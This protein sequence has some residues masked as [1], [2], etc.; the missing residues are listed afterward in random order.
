MALPYYRRRL[1]IIK[2]SIFTTH[3]IMKNITQHPISQSHH[4]NLP[5]HSTLQPTQPRLIHNSKFPRFTTVQQKWFNT[6]LINIPCFPTNT[7]L[8][9]LN[10]VHAP[11]CLWCSTIT[12]NYITQIK[13]SPRTTKMKPPLTFRTLNRITTNPLTTGTTSI[14]FRNTTFLPI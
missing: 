11:P 4:T 3:P 6:T 10:F 12:T 7:S 14:N 5:V 13:I 2:S 8:N 9:S 1:W